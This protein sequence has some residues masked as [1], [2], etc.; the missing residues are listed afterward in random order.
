MTPIEAMTAFKLDMP[1]EH[2]GRIYDK[3]NMI[4]YKKANPGGEIIMSLQ[5]QDS[6]KTTIDL[7]VAW[8]KPVKES[9]AN[10]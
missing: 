6:E 5:V 4:A 1:I 8:C 3:I 10:V 7:N 2:N 9:M